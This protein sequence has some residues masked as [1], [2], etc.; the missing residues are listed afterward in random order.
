MQRNN[1]FTP[2]PALYLTLAEFRQACLLFIVL[3]FISS[4]LCSA[5]V[6]E[7]S[8]LRSIFPPA[9]EKNVALSDDIREP[10]TSSVREVE[11]FNPAV[12]ALPFKRNKQPGQQS[13]MASRQLSNSSAVLPTTLALT[14]LNQ[15]NISNTTRED[16]EPSI[17]AVDKSGTTLI[18]TAYIGDAV[19]SPGGD[20]GRIRQHTRDYF[21]WQTNTV[22]LSR[23]VNGMLYSN[24]VDPYTTV[25]PYTSGVHPK[26]LYTIGLL[27]N[28]FGP[29]KRAIVVWR[30]DN[31]MTS[32]S[33]PV[34]LEESNT[35][36]YQLDK[37]HI[38]VSW[39]WRTRGRI[40][41]AYSRLKKGN[42]RII[43]KV[44]SDG[45][46]TF[47]NPINPATGNPSNNPIV[48][49]TGSTSNYQLGVYLVVSPY[50]GK[51][52]AFWTDFDANQ[53][54]WSMS[55][56]QGFSWTPASV[57]ANASDRFNKMVGQPT[58]NGSIRAPSLLAAR[59]NW[60][61][62]EI[63]VV[64]H[65]CNAQSS[66]HGCPTETDVFYARLVCINASNCVTTPVRINDVTTGDQFMPA[67]DFNAAGNLMVTFYDRRNDLAN[68]RY[69]LF[70][71]WINRFGQNLQPNEVASSF[72]SDL[73]AGFLGDYH[74]TYS[75]TISGT[76]HFFSAW[77]GVTGGQ[78]D[79]YVSELLP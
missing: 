77:I 59:Y 78:K 45:G 53:I 38:A 4:A 1:Q 13:K 16:A 47:T 6:S 34:V 11:F 61:A 73:N 37:P 69:Q 8:V 18:S 57:F 14:M 26:R 64:W 39:Y 79:A 42:D 55:S 49:N 48:I 3:L 35:G 32:W 31:P 62:G 25:N 40:F 63:D 60:P 75:H 74:E 52:F 44:S 20:T 65:E 58:L 7:D 68:N 10:I 28:D 24:S 66:G 21:T 54:R 50:S 70:S 33:A 71:A 36:S 76:E 5:P 51:L 67:L 15:M 22:V 72:Q 9:Y 2:P 27:T 41:A 17:V 30:S 43:I 23:T 56:N 12:A 29:A 46:Q 19:F